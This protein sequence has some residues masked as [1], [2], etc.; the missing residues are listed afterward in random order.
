MPSGWRAGPRHRSRAFPPQILEASFTQAAEEIAFGILPRR[1]LRANPR[2][3]KRKMSKYAVK[4]PEHRAWPQPTRPSEDAVVIIGAYVNSI[5]LMPD[6]LWS[7]WWPHAVT[8]CSDARTRLPD[9]LSTERRS[10]PVCTQ[11]MAP[12]PAGFR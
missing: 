3:V 9:S 4:R 7:A 11:R 5:A 12:V 6:P 2:V 10:T 8:A 1:P